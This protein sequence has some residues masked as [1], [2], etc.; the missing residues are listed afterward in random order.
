MINQ[1]PGPSPVFNA[2]LWRE[3]WRIYLRMMALLRPHWFISIC[4]VGCI[5]LNNAFALIVPSL[6][7]WVVDV[8]VHT[9]RFT[10]LLL[11]ATAIL[12][13]S[14]LRGLAAWARLLRASVV[15]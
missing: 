2:K 3:G 14:M 1:K 10:D 13:V 15:E 8:G 9:G 12:G 4:T 5:I 11:V 6:L 7:Q